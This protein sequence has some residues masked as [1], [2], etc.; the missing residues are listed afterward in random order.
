MGRSGIRIKSA[1]PRVDNERMTH[2]IEQEQLDGIFAFHKAQ[3]GSTFKH[4]RSVLLDLVSEAGQIIVAG[5]GGRHI[6]ERKG[7]NDFSTRTDKDVEKR[8]IQRIRSEFS[9]H[10]I[11]G[12]EFGESGKAA[13]EWLWIVDPIDGTTN[14]EAAIPF[15]A[16]SAGLSFRG[17]VVIGAIYDPLRGELFF[18]QQDCGAWLGCHR[19]AVSM[20]E[21]ISDAC[22][23]L[24][25]SYDDAKAV[26]LI[27]VMQKLTPLV[28]TQ[29]ILGSAALALAYVACGRLDAFCHN[30][31]RAWDI[32]AGSL[33]VTESKGKVTDLGGREP[34]DVSLDGRFSVAATNGSIHEH[35]LA[36]IET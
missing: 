29:R 35:L 20:T 3:H 19:I 1:T 7:R 4:P 15:L 14:F 6:I 9:D 10:R 34:F 11:L 31:L 36:A 5:F 21:A 32:A 24:D 2:Q 33:L 13:G 25:L 30:D 27:K 18:A 16:V 28:R 8:I 12:E 22:L 17:Q 23:G 26:Q